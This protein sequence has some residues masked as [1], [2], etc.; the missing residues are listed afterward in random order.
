MGFSNSRVS[1]TLLYSLTYFF[2]FL[3]LPN[4][5]AIDTISANQSITDGET[6][7]SSG[8]I[9]ELGFFSPGNSTNRYVGIWYKKTSY[10]QVVWVLNGLNPILDSH[11]S[12]SINNE[13]NLVLLD[14]N[15]NV[16]WY[17]NASS[18][19]SS[20]NST[21]AILNDEGNF[22]LSDN[23][24]NV[25]LW[26]SF[27]HPSNTLIPNMKL[28]GNDK[29]GISLRLTSWVSENNPAPGNF[30]LRRNR[31]QVEQIYIMSG[32]TATIVNGSNE[33]THWSSGQWNGQ[34]FM[35]IPGMPQ[36]YINGITFSS[37][38]NGGQ[39]YTYTTSDSSNIS[40]DI[41]DSSGNLVTKNWDDQKKEWVDI[42]SAISSQCD[43]YGTC[44][45]FGICNKTEAVICSCMT[46]FQP[47]FSD[48]WRNGNWSDG[49]VRSTPLQCGSGSN[50]S[51]G[52]G[53]GSDQ[54]GFLKLEG[55]KLPDLAEYSSAQD[56]NTCNSSCFNNC[57]CLAYAYVT[58]P[59]CMV[60]STDLIDVQQFSSGGEDLYLRVPSSL[61]EEHRFGLNSSTIRSIPI[62]GL[63]VSQ[64]IVGFSGFYLDRLKVRFNSPNGQIK[65][66]ENLLVLDHV[67][68]NSMCASAI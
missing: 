10:T 8:N 11:G 31:Q 13:G 38:G 44:G 39:Y 67:G 52:S 27:D 32:S 6:L 47:K 53:S 14:G 3:I 66:V 51:S 50:S 35:G 49:C 56:L 16:I 12:L 17:K 25:S 55:V 40:I 59:G 41:L 33:V 54:D 5:I 24:S 42:W 68:S 60:W 29:L 9:F 15:Q 26:D 37:D 65:K 63:D 19:M 18:T 4:C 2:L 48:R 20:N 34:S 28:G 46:G 58:D 1:T 36:D 57:S 23:Q 61:L 62:S 30:F 64:S 43:V 7:V 22:I 21:V 45:P